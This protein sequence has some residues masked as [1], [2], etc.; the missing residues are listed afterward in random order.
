VFHKEIVK[1]E[2]KESGLAQIIDF[3]SGP[4]YWTW[5]IFSFERE[6]ILDLA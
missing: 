2:I 6:T 4:A 5:G 3:Y 1:R